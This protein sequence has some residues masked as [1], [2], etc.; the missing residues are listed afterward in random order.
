[1][2]PC[3]SSVPRITYQYVEW[4]FN[5]EKIFSWFDNLLYWYG[6]IRWIVAKVS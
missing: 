1:M 3:K 5:I 4:Q 6:G 2:I